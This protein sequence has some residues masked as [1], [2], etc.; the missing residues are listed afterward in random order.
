[1]NLKFALATVLLSISIP[2]LAEG[3]NNKGTSNASGS[4]HGSPWSSR[5][6]GGNAGQKQGSGHHSGGHHKD[7]SGNDSQPGSNESGNQQQGAGGSNNQQGSNN[8]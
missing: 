7:K 2:A 3:D 1:M 8:N 4:Y 5:H 6:Q